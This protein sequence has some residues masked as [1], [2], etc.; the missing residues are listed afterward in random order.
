MNPARYFIVPKIVNA[1]PPSASEGKANAGRWRCSS[2]LLIRCWFVALAGV[3]TVSAGVPFTSNYPR[4]R[5]GSETASAAAVRVST[6]GPA[7]VSCAAF[8]H[9]PIHFTT[10]LAS[11][12]G[13]SALPSADTIVGNTAPLVPIGC[14]T[15]PLPVPPQRTCLH[16]YC[17]VVCMCRSR[18]T[19]TD[20]GRSAVR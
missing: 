2:L 17:D 3:V 18:M 6:T 1:R 20:S 12:S 13:Q 4:V 16:H 11:A 10:I 15:G 8:R 7:N 9:A 14:C 19:Q 5:Q